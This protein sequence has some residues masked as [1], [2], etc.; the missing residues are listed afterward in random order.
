MHGPKMNEPFYSK[1]AQ[2]GITIEVANRVDINKVLVKYYPE[3]KRITKINKGIR[4]I[5]ENRS[6]IDEFVTN[7]SKLRK[8]LEMI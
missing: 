8:G 2:K 3:K 4:F 1:P 6:M 7:I 5:K